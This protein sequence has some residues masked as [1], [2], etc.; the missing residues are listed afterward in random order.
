MNRHPSWKIRLPRIRVNEAIAAVE[1]ASLIYTRA[2][3]S[4]KSC[5]SCHAAPEKSFKTWAASMPQ[6]EPRLKK[7]IGV[8][9]FITRHARATT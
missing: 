2:G 4:G 7:V 1:R 5:A 8:E 3:S 9:E 6:Y